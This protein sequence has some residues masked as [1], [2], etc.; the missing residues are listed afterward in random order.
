MA[1]PFDKS[2]TPGP[3][4]DP[5]VTVAKILR[6][7]GLRGTFR[8]KPLT[9]A[10]DDL[11]ESEIEEFHI[12]Q[13]GVIVKTL[14]RASATLNGDLIHMK[15]KEI[16]RRSEAE[17]FTNAELV[18]PEELRWDLPEGEY[19]A[20]DLKN[21]TLVD[22]ETGEVVGMCLEC[23]EGTAHDY[24]RIHLTGKPE[25]TELLPFVDEFVQELDLEQGVVKVSIPLGL[26]DAP[27]PSPQRHLKPMEE[28]EE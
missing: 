18:I 6:P 2:T 17:V 16:T 21:L 23:V 3:E 27:P 24:L 12:R 8:L 26:F 20:D 4:N 11:I 15:F 22:S 9:G 25:H 14:H 1:S 19:Y 10:V 7:H 5:W 13:N 28:D